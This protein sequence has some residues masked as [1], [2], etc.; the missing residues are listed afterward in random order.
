MN[1]EKLFIQILEPDWQFE[2][3]DYDGIV[4]DIPSPI[5]E[6]NNEIDLSKYF[7]VPK[8]RKSV[9]GFNSKALQIF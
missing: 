1:D 2:L 5:I 8:N 4:T 7:D 6:N 3:Y 9:K